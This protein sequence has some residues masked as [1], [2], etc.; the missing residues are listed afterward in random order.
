MGTNHSREVSVYLKWEPILE[1]KT[2]HTCSGNQ[3]HEGREFI[4]GVGTSHGREE[5]LYLEWEQNH[6][7][8]ERLY[9]EWEP[10][11]GGKRV[12]T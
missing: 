4:H 5:S 12:Y 11:A 1:R 3:S 10:I 9:L 7:M 2:V 8:E 6:R